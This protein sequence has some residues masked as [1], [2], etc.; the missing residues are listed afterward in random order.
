MASPTKAMALGGVSPLLRK[1]TKDGM[2]P[3][4]GDKGGSMAMKNNFAT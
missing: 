4:A 2:S 3:K 1:G